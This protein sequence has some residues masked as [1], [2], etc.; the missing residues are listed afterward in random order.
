[1]LLEIWVS[2]PT[3]LVVKERVP[4]MPTVNMQ[5]V[6]SGDGTVLEEKVCGGEVKMNS[7]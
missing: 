7:M 1:M 2:A 6:P 3:H 4:P 5:Q